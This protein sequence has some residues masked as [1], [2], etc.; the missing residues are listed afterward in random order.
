M[1][2]D[3]MLKKCEKLEALNDDLLT[4]IQTMNTLLISIGFPQGLNSLKDV[5][6]DVIGGNGTLDA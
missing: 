5:A 2:E 3:Q 1:T 6:K 4:E